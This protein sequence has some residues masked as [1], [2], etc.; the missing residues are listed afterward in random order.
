VPDDAPQGTQ[1]ITVSFENAEINT[2]F[3]V[4]N[5]IPLW[6]L[7]LAGIATVG[8]FGVA[9]GGGI[10]IVRTLQNGRTSKEKTR[11]KPRKAEPD[12]QLKVQMD[13]G[14][15]SVEEKGPSLTG[16]ADIHFEVS[17]DPGEQEINTEGDSLIGG[18]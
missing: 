14:T 1:F 15:Q 4:T 17:G 7:V 12:F 13:Y 16:K 18:D 2:T 6:I 3:L 9:V 11:E 5:K 10:A 8:A